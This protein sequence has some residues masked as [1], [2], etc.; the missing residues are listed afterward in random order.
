MDTN[1]IVIM[2]T[3]EYIVR[4]VGLGYVAYLDLEIIVNF[5]NAKFHVRDIKVKEMKT[6]RTDIKHEVNQKH[7]ISLP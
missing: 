4:Q 6:S 1:V 2:A 3:Q 7:Y 5:S